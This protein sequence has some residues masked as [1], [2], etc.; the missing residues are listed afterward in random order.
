MSTELTDEVSA[1]SFKKVENKKRYNMKHLKTTIKLS[2]LALACLGAGVLALQPTAYAKAED[3]GFDYNANGVEVKKMDHPVHVGIVK[4]S[5]GDG[6]KH[7]TITHT[8]SEKSSERTNDFLCVYSEP[9]GTNDAP[10]NVGYMI[11]N[12]KVTVVK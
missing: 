10:I 3:E 9:F 12:I 4:T 8:V 11:D 6:W 1:S 5:S 7:C 2:V